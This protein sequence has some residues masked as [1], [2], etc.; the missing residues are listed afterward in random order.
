M[1]GAFCLPAHP[2]KKRIPQGA[3]FC[4]F[5]T[6]YLIQ[7]QYCTDVSAVKGGFTAENAYFEILFNRE[8]LSLFMR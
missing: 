5:T 2:R 6:L 3:R 4:F 8:A 1:K 7:V